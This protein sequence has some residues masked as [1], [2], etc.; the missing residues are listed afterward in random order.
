LAFF[1]ASGRKIEGKAPPGSH[2]GNHPLNQGEITMAKTW[3]FSGTICTFTCL[4]FVLTLSFLV[5]P[6]LAGGYVQTNLVSD[7]L[8]L[9]ANTDPNLINP[10]GI[11][12]SPTSPFWVSNNRT[13]VATLYNGAGQPFP[14]GGPLVVTIPP[15]GVGTGTPTGQVFN[16]TADFEVSP[17]KPARFIFATENGTISG[18]NPTANATNAILKVDNS[19]AG[20]VYTGLGIGNNGSGNFLYAANFSNGTINVFDSTFSPAFLSGSFFDPNLPSGYAPF[21]VQYLGGSLLVT[22]ASTSGAGPGRGFVDVFDLN[23]NLDRRLISG[24]VLNSPW[25]LALAPANFGEFSND[26][27]V[28]NFGDGT[29]NAFDPTTGIW[30]GTLTD[31]LNNPISIDGLRGLIFGNGSNG[32][33]PNMLYFTAGIGDQAHGLFGSL[34]PVPAPATLML[35]GSGLAGL[36]GWRRFRMR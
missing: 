23:G 32:A 30:I 15:S 7:Q 36:V 28:G 4:V 34:A 8:G 31:S 26:L 2:L 6:A 10:W 33:D 21:N 25:G 3:R 18:W 11:S 20:A 17:G 14:V 16:G 13:G 29:I 22:Y 35:L 24:G 27:L 1:F 19:A 5:F 9:A 12:H